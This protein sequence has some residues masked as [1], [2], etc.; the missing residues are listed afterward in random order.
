MLKDNMVKININFK[1]KNF[2]KNYYLVGCLSKK[3]K[4]ELLILWK[5][6]GINKCY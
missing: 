2:K 4:G 5:E 3:K 6:E 1:I